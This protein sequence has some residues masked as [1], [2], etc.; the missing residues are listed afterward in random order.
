MKPFSQKLDDLAS[1]LTPSRQRIPLRWLLL[2][3]FTALLAGTT[4]LVGYLSLQAGEEVS[5]ELANRLLIQTTAQIETEVKTYLDLPHRLNQ[6]VATAVTEGWIQTENQASERFLWQLLDQHPTLGLIYFGESQNG[7]F[8]G[9]RRRADRAIEIMISDSTT[10]FERGYYRTDQRGWRDSPLRI[11]PDPYDARTRPWYRLALST[12]EP[13][14]TDPYPSATSGELLITATQPVYDLDGQTLLGVVGADLTLADIST[15]LK[16]LQLG[17][18]GSAFILTSEDEL[19]A[20]SGPDLSESSNPMSPSIAEI[21]TLLDPDGTSLQAIE[22]IWRTQLTWQNQDFYVA[23]SRFED[24]RGLVWASVVVIPEAEVLSPIWR[25]RQVILGLV[26][27]F[28]VFSVGISIALTRQIADPIAELSEASSSL[29]EGSYKVIPNKSGIQEIEQV[30]VAFNQMSLRLQRSLLALRKLNR[31]LEE[32][33]QQRTQELQASETLFR[34]VFENSPVGI[35]LNDMGSKQI[36]V[37]PSLV[38]LLGYSAKEL[39]GFVTYQHYTHPDDLAQDE[40]LWQHLIN[41][42]TDQYTLEKRCIRKDGKL[43]WVR[44]SMTLIRDQEGH[45]TMSLAMLRDITIDK[46]AEQRILS[47]T[48]FL[49]QL[50]D[51]LPE[52]IVVRTAQHQTYLINK[53]YG[54]FYYG[55]VDRHNL[56]GS[57]ESQRFAGFWQTIVDENN[58]ILA[59]HQE[60]KIPPHIE[61]GANGEQRWIQFVKRPLT[62]PES[63]QIGILLVGNDI[64]VLKEAQDKAEAANQAKSTFLANMSHELRTPLNAVIGFSQLMLRDPDLT[65]KQR[66]TLITIN[67]SGE[68]LLGLINDVLDLAKIE[69]G[70]MVLQEDTFDLHDTLKTLHQILSIRAKE[71]GIRLSFER[72]PDVPQVIIGDGK[73]LRQVL[74]NLVGNGIKFTN[75][76]EV[77]VQVKYFPNSSHSNPEDPITLH[78]S[79]SDTGLG[80]TPEELGMLFQSF[81]QTDTSKKVSEGT[82]LGLAISRQFVQLMGGDITVTSQK[83]VGST[84]SFQIRVKPA[85]E[86]ITAPDAAQQVVGLAPGQPKYRLLVVDD[87]PDNRAVLQQLFTG[88][89]FE[90]R[91]ASNGQEALEI[92]QDWNPHLI[93]MDV[94][95]PVMDGFEATQQIREWITTRYPQR[96]TKIIALSASGFEYDRQ[97]AEASG[98][99]Q[100]IFKPFR[101][102]TLFEVLQQHLQVEFSYRTAQPTAHQTLAADPTLL[103]PDSL[104]VMSPDWIRQFHQAAISL[105]N[106]RMKALIEA[107]PDEQAELAA[108]LSLM[109]KKVMIDP[110]LDLTTPLVKS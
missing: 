37:S 102:S 85:A 66:E 52:L 13:A 23:V 22:D 80:M 64:T 91:E 40:E 49:N 70:K 35:A 20:A 84:F 9:S 33:V 98:F 43:I 82:G 76:G 94:R 99:D 1:E 15:F 51:T 36:K 47:Q 96:Q 39:Q 97:K 56:I 27:L 79:V 58:Q 89:G 62:L 95:M 105:N 42:A 74:I 44:V 7:A 100:Y 5:E 77:T 16:G 78:F 61:I 55:T 103:T 45:P 26:I 107:I 41:G 59:T 88:L 18:S 28:V 38:H 83:G 93:W 73:K 60:I 87:A 109:V 21:L 10:G 50:I 90:I 75:Q 2:V 19:I 86:T 53:S 81:V 30:R 25:T 31:E 29:S 69:A 67:R 65:D 12:G 101:E 3:P 54:D 24:L 57:D 32:R 17:T 110:I 92:W 106:R 46:E 68:H 71:K 108:T 14:W 63:G 34:G 72:S 48:E 104:R 6:M 11:D 4:A 8:V